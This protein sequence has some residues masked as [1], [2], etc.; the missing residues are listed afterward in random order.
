LN[1]TP[2]QEKLCGSEKKI[3]LSAVANQRAAGIINVS[4]TMP[5]KMAAALE[6]RARQDMT[7]KSEIVRR[8]IMAYLP[9]NEAKALLESVLAEEPGP[10]PPSATA[11][12]KKVTYPKGKRRMTSD[13]PER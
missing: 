9:E 6:R 7:N 12:M 10:P 3:H 13:Q 8:A 1:N 5:A 11:P 2:V 4:F